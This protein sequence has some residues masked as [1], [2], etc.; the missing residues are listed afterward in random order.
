VVEAGETVMLV[1]L[2]TDVAPHDPLYHRHVAPLPRLPP[3]TD[4]VDEPP[5]GTFAGEAVA[6][7]AAVDCVFDVTVAL[8]QAV[9]LHVPS[10]RT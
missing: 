1:P 5:L 10:A 4:T 6:L 9:V 8:A 7:A 3:D 2:P